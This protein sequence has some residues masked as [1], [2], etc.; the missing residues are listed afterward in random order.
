VEL[1]TPNN[2]GGNAP[3]QAGRDV[4]RLS[5][6]SLFATF[7]G[8]GLLTLA[9]GRS[10]SE[11]VQA[12]QPVAVRR[13]SGPGPSGPIKRGGVLRHRLRDDYVNLDPH[14][15]ATASAQWVGMLAYSRLLRFAI[16]P[17]QNNLVPELI[18]EMTTDLGEVTDGSK[19]VFRLRP[20]IFFHDVP[21]LYGRPVTAT[22]VRL[23]FERARAGK[24][25][26]SL[27]SIESVQ[28][29]DQRTIVLVLRR[30]TITLPMVLASA[31]GLFVMPY[32]VDVGFNAARTP[33][34]A[35]PWMM[36]RLE[37]A[38]QVRWK[39]N[40]RY[41]MKG[42]DNL[43]LP[44]AEY[45]VE[46]VIPEDPTAT[47]QF[48]AGELDLLEM[49]SHDLFAV[50]DT[51][52]EAQ[53][54]AF[55][56]HGFSFMG[57]SAR[58]GQPYRDPRIRRA[59]SLAL[60]RPA[61]SNVSYDTDRLEQAGYPVLRKQPS[62]PLPAHFKYWVDP[63]TQPWGYFYGYQPTEAR[64]LLE[65]AG[66]D[67]N[68]MIPLNFTSNRFG[69]EYTHSV[70]AVLQLLGRI[71]VRVQLVGHDYASAW[72]DVWQRGEFDGIGY[73]VVARFPDPHD[74]FARIAHSRGQF[75]PGRVRDPVL[76]TLIEKEDLVFD[77]DDRE[78]LAREIVNRVNEQM[79]IPP[80]TVGTTM[81]YN[82]S[83]PWLGNAQQYY[84]T[85]T[86]AWYAEVF[87][88]YWLQ[89]EP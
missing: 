46:K 24:T 68:T 74:Y 40:P 11:P 60:D 26:A 10:R 88:H 65:A 14:A 3:A 5:R 70:E 18:P 4:R 7:A 83:Q 22:D 72:A 15:T 84:T 36:E 50:Q 34:G 53:I 6:R 2:R 32:E 1:R 9:C 64:R 52:P 33:I 38:V 37:P 71:G 29:P 78:E 35:G 23:S 81:Q 47:A 73:F 8:A 63:D 76:D 17:G 86:G 13:P 49:A 75:N 48:S 20:D 27:S 56:Q 16:G 62:S 54:T 41:F 67:F 30:P 31:N 19:A 45:L 82:V 21:P 25:G 85:N 80:L 61:L 55:P 44:Y 43:P 89:S 58:P 79:Y 59:F 12:V 77:A 87:P 69:R 42:A 66:W 51:V 28:T 39:A 57:F